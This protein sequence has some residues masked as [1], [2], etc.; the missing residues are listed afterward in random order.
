[1]RY[2]VLI[3][4]TVFNSSCATQSVKNKT[5]VSLGDLIRRGEDVYVEGERF[6]NEI[7]FASYVDNILV[8]EGVYEGKIRS[9]IVF[10]NCIFDGSVRSFKRQRDNN[11]VTVA[12]FLGSLSFIG[13][14]FKDGVNFRGSTVYGR[15]DF[16]GSVF[17]EVANF[18][19][20]SFKQN[21]FFNWSKFEGEHR[22]QNSFFLQKANF[23]NTEYYENASFQSCTFNSELQLGVSKFYRY[24]DFSLMDCRGNALFNYSEFNGRADFSHSYFARGL[25]FVHTRNNQ[26]SFSKSRF[27]G[28]VRFFELV[29]SGFIDF[30]GCF[31]LIGKPQVD[32]S[33]EKI[34]FD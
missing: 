25:D 9:S 27:M 29:V 23:M 3:L 33:K 34:Y 18:E 31:F 8:S 16:T 17:K 4:A 19:E 12:S 11:E 28:D 20:C 10:K 21:A 13:C 5:G 1:M 24:A 22:F 26:T 14:T 15:V 6:E 30:R 7:D 2:V 32:I